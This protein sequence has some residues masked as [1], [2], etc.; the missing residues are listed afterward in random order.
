MD[1][2]THKLEILQ[3]KETVCKACFTA[4]PDAL[5]APKGYYTSE[6]S[7]APIVFD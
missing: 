6:D 1:A 2:V 4:I 5:F 3:E 7:K